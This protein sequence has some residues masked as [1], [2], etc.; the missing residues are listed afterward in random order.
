MSIRHNGKTIKCYVHRLIGE[1][2]YSLQPGEEID[3]IDHC[4]VDNS[5]IRVVTRAQNT[6]NARGQKDKSSRFKG[7]SWI[8]DKGKWYACICLNGK[9]V[10]L[11]KFDNE[12]VAAMAYDVAAK[13]A[14]GEFAF[15]NMRDA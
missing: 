3:H 10:S 15:L 8:A 5:K 12:I 11:G 1:A 7:V 2:F 9:T 4:R 13:R 6:H 14:W